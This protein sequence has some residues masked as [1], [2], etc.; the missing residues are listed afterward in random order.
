MTSTTYTSTCDKSKEVSRIVDFS[1]A[2][3]IA[4]PPVAL[5]HLVVDP[6]A[7]VESKEAEENHQTKDAN[8]DCV[9]GLCR[10]S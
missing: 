7:E 2:V 3:S 9:N 6:V 10:F 4:L 5:V 1:P 8:V